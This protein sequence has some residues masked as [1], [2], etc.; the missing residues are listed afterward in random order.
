[1]VSIEV[2]VS[3]Q[4]INNK[5]AMEII[6]VCGM[7]RCR[8]YICIGKTS[9]FFACTYIYEIYMFKLCV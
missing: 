7:Q 4:E 1:M 2:F 3:H 8:L 6:M 5:F 9:V